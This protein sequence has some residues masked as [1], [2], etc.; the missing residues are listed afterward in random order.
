MDILASSEW[1]SATSRNQNDIRK[2]SFTTLL[3]KIQAQEVREL[4]Y[5]LST[6]SH[7]DEKQW[8]QTEPQ[9]ANLWK[10]LLGNFSLMF[11]EILIRTIWQ[12]TR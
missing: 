6:A 3:N 10:F 11:F 7:G 9:I 8:D 5:D 4:S 1:N 2:D 12:P